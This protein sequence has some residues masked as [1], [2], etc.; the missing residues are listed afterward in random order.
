MGFRKVILC[1][2][3]FGVAV[4]L[5]Q[6]LALSSLNIQ[7]SPRL[8]WEAGKDGSESDGV[9]LKQEVRELVKF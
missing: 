8:P 7:N 3:M 6:M 1:L 5:I 9:K 2:L 4:L